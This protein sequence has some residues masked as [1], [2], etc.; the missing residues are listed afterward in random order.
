MAAPHEQEEHAQRKRGEDKENNRG[1]NLI[2]NKLRK[3]PE[4]CTERSLNELK[5][6]LNEFLFKDFIVK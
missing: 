2:S 3:V 1:I 4:C 6:V 5:E